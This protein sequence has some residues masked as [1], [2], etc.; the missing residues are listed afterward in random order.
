[1]SVIKLIRYFKYNYYC[2]SD[3]E[4]VCFR[5]DLKFSRDDAFLISA[6]ILFHKVSAAT[7]NAQLPYDLSRETGTCNSIWLDDLR[8]PDDFIMETS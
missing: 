1:M 4:H 7:L 2:E 5:T 3:I 8:F 6:G